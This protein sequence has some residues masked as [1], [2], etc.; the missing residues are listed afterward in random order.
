MVEP[1]CDLPPVA[2]RP[3]LQEGRRIALVCVSNWYPNKGLLELLDAVAALPAGDA[4]VHLA[5][6][7]D[8]DADYGDLCVGASSIPISQRR[9]VAH[10]VID[11]QAV[12]ELYAGP[13][14]SC[15]P[16]TSRAMRR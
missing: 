6:R 10:G 11:R 16:A 8:V 13:M 5:G 7:D 3:D 1:G 12:A 4:T 14:S 2:R 15:C 9:V